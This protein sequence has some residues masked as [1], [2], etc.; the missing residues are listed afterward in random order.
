MQR[1]DLQSKTGSRGVPA[2][3]GAVGYGS[4]VDEVVA[5]RQVAGSVIGVYYPHYNH[6]YSVAALTDRSGAVVER[7][8]YEAQPLA[9][10]CPIWHGGL[11]IQ[12][13]HRLYAY[14]NHIIA[15]IIKTTT[16]I[17]A[18]LVLTGLCLT[19]ALAV[20][21]EPSPPPAVVAVPP[22]PAATPAAVVVPRWAASSGRDQYGTWADL[23]VAG[24]TQ[25]FRWIQPG[26]FTM[27][28]AQAEKDAALASVPNSNP[29]WFTGE[30]Q[31]QVTLTKG[32]W[33]ADS[34]CTQAL[35]Q[36][37]MG[38]NPSHFTGSPQSP[39]EGVSWDDCQEF[40]STLNGRVSGGEFRLPC[41]A[42]WEYACRAGTT[43]AF[44]F[45]VTITPE[46]V[47]CD[48]NFPF[49]GTAKGLDRQTTMPVKRVFVKSLPPNAWGI[50]EMHGN[51]REWCNDWYGSFSG[52]AERDPTGPSSGSGRVIRGGGGGDYARYCRSAY[53]GWLTPVK[54]FAASGF[55][56]VAQAT[57]TSESSAASTNF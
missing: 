47:N 8:T 26:T 38:A 20:T 2:A 22:T 40:L 57:P 54:R 31:H 33:L 51:V 13:R 10:V 50:H 44:S 35:W 3:S 32:Y 25:R 46:Q 12:D 5:Y 28:S 42:Q 14:R 15:M 55:R 23:Q 24:V 4:Y 53:R 52:S 27:G 48:G 56:F 30:V 21:A 17:P 49:G 1:D 34:E 43:T 18:G 45:G 7:Y 29:E 39:V 36:A 6:L 16:L 9:L 19:A 41:E 37:I 11:T